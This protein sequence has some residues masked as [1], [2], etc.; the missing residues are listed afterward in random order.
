MAT[1]PDTGAGGADEGPEDPDDCSR[2]L[3]EA[4]S[5]QT[6]AFCGGVNVVWMH[7]LATDR[8]Q[9]RSFG[10]DDTPPSFWT[11]CEGC[12]QLYQNGEDDELIAS[13]KL[14]GGWIW[15]GADVED[16]LRKP[17]DVFRSADLGRRPIRKA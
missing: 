15:Q 16:V 7:P 14:A 12:E 4:V 10:K 6:C 1:S 11:L 8:V 17:V 9:F 5:G 2:E 3:P 13:M